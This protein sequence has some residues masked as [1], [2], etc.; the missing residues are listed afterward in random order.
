MRSARG[1]RGIQVRDLRGI[2]SEAHTHHKLLTEE[3][4]L[5]IFG[6]PDLTVSLINHSFE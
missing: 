3:I 5:K 1:G 2:L 6:S 4:G